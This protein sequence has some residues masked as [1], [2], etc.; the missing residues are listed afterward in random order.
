M[1]GHLTD[2]VTVVL[3]GTPTPYR[4]RSAPGG[5]RYLPARQRDQLACLR[6]AAAESMNGRE[7]FATPVRLELR[8]TLPIP[9]SWSKK[10]QHAAMTG[11]ILPG[12]RPDLSNLLKLA[13]DALS[14]VVFADDSL[15]CIQWSQKIYG[16]APKI[17]IT[18]KSLAA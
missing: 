1:T 5:H 12:S 10:K 2:E 14:S 6:L 11:E 4:H 3:S 7:P 15:V 8:V 16:L 13:E 17:V 18:V 9:K